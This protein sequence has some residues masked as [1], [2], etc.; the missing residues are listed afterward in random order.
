MYFNR[1]EAKLAAKASMSQAQPSYM[2]VMVAYL[3]LTTGL[4][5]FV[6]ALI[7]TPWDNILIYLQQG[8]T[9]EAVFDYLILQ[10]LDRVAI[11]GVAQFILGL[12]CTVVEFGL[13]SYTL[14]LARNE[15]PGIANLFDG[16]AKAG[17]VIWMGILISLFVTLWAA[18]LFVPAIGVMAAAVVTEEEMYLL[19]Y[20]ILFMGGFA[21]AMV[22]SYRYYLSAYFLLDD[23]GCTARQAIR[24]SKGS[25]KGHKKEAFILDFSFFGWLLLVAAIQNVFMALGLGLAGVIAGTLA[26]GVLQLWLSPYILTTRAN[27][28]NYV[29]GLQGG[30]V[31]PAGG[32]AGPEYDY[33]SNDGPEPF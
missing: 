28:Y 32:F 9:A 16:F 2:V 11:A 19:L 8:Y 10:Q 26:A 14:R 7:G 33:H 5:R 27:F 20:F 17:R 12:F 4:T 18:I 22:V 3:L 21:L 24:R 15:G 23:P 31:R 25:M 1:Y 6:M 30:P 13:I 29:V